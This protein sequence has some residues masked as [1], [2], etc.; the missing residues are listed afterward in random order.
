MSGI[1]SIL[2]AGGLGKRLWPLSREIHP[3]QLM[4]LAGD[5][6]L[7]QE[8]ARR[9]LLV[10]APEQVVTVTTE[11]LFLP[12]RDQLGAVDARLAGNVL[13]EPAGRNTAAAV[14]MAALHARATSGDPILFVAPADH[15][16]RDAQAI[17]G[18]VRL[19]AQAPDRLVM[20]GI[21]PDHP[22]TGYGYIVPGAPLHP[23][24]GI[25]GVDRFIEKPD[26]AAARD[27]F[28]G[29]GVLW[30]SGMFVFRAGLVLHEF[31]VHAPDVHAAVRAA[32]AQRRTSLG[33]W[34]F[35]R[36]AYE[37]IPAAPIDKA[38]MERTD[39]AAVIPID[40][41]WSDV[42]SWRT[43]WQANARDRDGNAVFGDAVLSGCRDTM[44]RG[45]SRL[46]AAA[47]LSGVAICETG[48]AVLVTTLDADAEVGAIVESLRTAG[49][50]E[51]V[52]HPAEQRPWGGF[53]VLLVG[54]GF[55]VKELTVKPGARLSL[56]SHRRRSEHWVVLEGVARVTCGDSVRDV[57]VN[58][59]TH[60]P[61]GV[62]HRLENPG[63]TPLRIVEVQCGDYVGEDDIVRYDDEYG[64]TE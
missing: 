40:P 38:V 63:A 26:T 17:A 27:L 13:L 51:V 6:S 16:V 41:G 32:H 34:R 59:S 53:R 45:E 55:K 33:A 57:G 35:P 8:A 54:D 44:V 28:S 37:A 56:Q 24:A 15:V 1:V 61:V 10:S 43:L 18:A 5:E 50:E 23:H 47:G 52:R 60:I 29:G 11:A 39:K 3:K 4:A 12:V 7:L 48:D 62:R 20:F 9:A 14:A 31:A 42:G 21:A 46:V 25:Y 58:E 2:L 64:R 49:R 19:A 30:N 36:A 22:E